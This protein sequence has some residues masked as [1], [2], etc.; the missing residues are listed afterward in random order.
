MTERRETKETARRHG[1]ISRRSLL[2]SAPISL[3][4]ARAAAQSQN[5][6]RR[7]IGVLYAPSDRFAPILDATFAGISAAAP[8]WTLDRKL[9]RPGAAGAEVEG[10][11]TADVSGWLLLGTEATQ[12]IKGRRLARPAVA[13]LQYLSPKDQFTD[14]GVSLDFDPEAVF[15]EL[16][17]LLPRHNRVHVI[18]IKGRD[19]WII[20]RVRQAGAMRGYSILPAAARSLGEA[21][22]HFSGALRFGNPATD[23]IWV[24][25]GSGL[26]TRD[27]SAHLFQQAYNARFPVFAGR[28]AWVEEGAFLGGEPD[29]R[30][31]GAQ[32]ARV[33]ER[34]LATKAPLFETA[35]KISLAMN[36]RVARRVG[37]AVTQNVRDRMGALIADD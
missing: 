7:R 2:L 26:I 31:H 16:N 32:L 4:F 19:D 17:S 1:A 34:V 3:A 8:H 13:G 22:D 30:E 35:A 18:H 15:P 9:I 10:L 36:V 23:V 14:G 21:T 12:L 28:R 6:G 24:L 25:G 27:T 5:A 11:L 37:V 29:F 20:E 33:L